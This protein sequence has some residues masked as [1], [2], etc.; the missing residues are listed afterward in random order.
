MSKRNGRA[1]SKKFPVNKLDGWD[2]PIAEA[3]QRIQDLEFSIR[4]FE[5]KKAAGEPCAAANPMS[6][7]ELIGLATA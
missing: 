6:D 3:K 2:A 7:S 4:V 5:R 1:I